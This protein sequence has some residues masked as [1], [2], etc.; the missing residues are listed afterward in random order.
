MISVQAVYTCENEVI[1]TLDISNS[2]LAIACS[3]GKELAAKY[4]KSVK[5]TLIEQKMATYE[6]VPPVRKIVNGN[7][8]P[9]VEDSPSVCE[10]LGRGD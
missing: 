4:N 8:Y 10:L 1:E 5:L 9:N 7:P 6:F 2:Q 3:Y